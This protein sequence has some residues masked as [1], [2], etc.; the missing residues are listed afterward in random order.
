MLTLAEKSSRLLAYITVEHTVK[1]VDL[2]YI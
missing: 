1:T 2:A